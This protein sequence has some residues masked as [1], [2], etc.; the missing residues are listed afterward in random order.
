MPREQPK[1]GQKDKKKKKKD[2]P[3]KE[4]HRTIVEFPGS[5]VVK[6]SALSLLWL[7]LLGL[8]LGPG[9]SACL[10]GGQK[11]VTFQFFTRFVE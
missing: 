10:E 8:I 4:V 2:I 7:R 11:M 3:D 9:T 1:K 6:D 5:L